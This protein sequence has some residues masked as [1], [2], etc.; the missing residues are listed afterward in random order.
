[1][2]Y[3]FMNRFETSTFEFPTRGKCIVF[4]HL[5]DFGLK[6]VFSCDFLIF[7]ASCEVH[8]HFKNRCGNATI[9]ST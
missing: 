4:K 1:M 9:C 8:N 3:D 7:D 5:W 2:I 6:F